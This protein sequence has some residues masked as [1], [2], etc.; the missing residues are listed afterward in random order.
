MGQ[1]PHEKLYFTKQD[2]QRIPATEI[3][4]VSADVRPLVS[5]LMITWNHEEHIAQAIESVLNQKCGLPF[6][7]IIG[8]DCS[9]DRTRVICADFQRRFPEKIRL[10]VAD[11]NVGM[12]RNL[13]RIWCRAKGK[14]IA[15]C[16]GDDYWNDPEKLAKQTA[17]MEAR[18]EFTLCGTY[19]QKIMMD[20]N[21]AWVEAGIVGPSE[22]KERYTL[23]D[24]IP[25]YTFHFSSVLLRKECV[26]FPLWFWDM[27]CGDRPLYLL[28]AEKGP[29]GF[30]PG[31]TSVYR[32]HDGGIWASINQLDKARKGIKLFETIDMHFGYRYD[33]LIRRTLG[34]ILWSYMAEVLE[35]GDRNT[36][37]TLFW[38]SMH[39]KFSELER[40]QLYTVLI[41]LLRLYSP[42]L[43]KQT[44]NLKEKISTL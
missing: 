3:S 40:S 1:E 41:V 18:P 39:Y 34:N 37:K 14:Y 21:G 13:S 19:T 28:C 7:L 32:L 22:I 31:I 30:I 11:E 36:A 9:Q 25:S 33:K 24:L 20:E 4:N 8:E 26:R 44:K 5:V 38:K 23:E 12:H 27:Y 17:W 35:S 16:E 6:E 15:L 10:I 42:F 29:A 2:F 43:Y